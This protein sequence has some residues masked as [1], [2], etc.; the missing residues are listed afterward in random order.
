MTP[1]ATNMSDSASELRIGEIDCDGL[2][3]V[4]RLCYDAAKAEG[5]CA[6]VHEGGGYYA[7]RIIRRAIQQ[8]TLIVAETLTR[9]TPP[10]EMVER[11]RRACMEAG[12]GMDERIPL[13]FADA[14]AA[15]SI[16]DE[17]PIP[18]LLFCP[19][20]GLK[21]IDEPD[22]W[23]PDWD[24]PPHKSHLC[25]GCGCIW[26]PADVPTE[27]VAS[28]ETRGKADTWSV[29]KQAM[30]ADVPDERVRVARE[31]LEPFAAMAEYLDNTDHRRDAIY[32]GGSPGLRCQV[33]QADY[34]RARH[35]FA[36]LDEGAGR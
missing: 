2:D 16:P 34:H 21:H 12:K 14:V 30:P 10:V 17:K 28:I 35:A 13:M 32:C 9:T 36:S 8:G 22:E 31:A 1:S 15:A 6:N 18:M 19:N 20:C 24:N 5:V 29:D 4:E 3:A 25:H 27:G 23:S 33:T 26:R 7:E 11:V